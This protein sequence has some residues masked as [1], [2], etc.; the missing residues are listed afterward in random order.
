MPVALPRPEGGR[1]CRRQGSLRFKKGWL[2]PNYYFKNVNLWTGCGARQ[3]ICNN[4]DIHINS[5]NTTTI[6][7]ELFSKYLINLENLGGRTKPPPFSSML[8]LFIIYFIY[9]IPRYLVFVV[10]A[11]EPEPPPSEGGARR[12]AEPRSRSQRPHFNWIKDI[13]SFHKECKGWLRPHN[14][15]NLR[16]RGSASL[17]YISLFWLRSWYIKILLYK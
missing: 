12:L 2:R 14:N 10:R 9:F 17:Q 5:S 7:K 1:G 6:N 4:I 16:R 11:A 15:S 13:T 8:Y 3:A